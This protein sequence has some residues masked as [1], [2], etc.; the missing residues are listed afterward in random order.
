M[1]DVLTPALTVVDQDPYRL[2]TLA[3]ERIFARLDDDAQGERAV[4]SVI[5]VDLIERASCGGHDGVS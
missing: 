1:A 4:V 3:A 2:G 5:D